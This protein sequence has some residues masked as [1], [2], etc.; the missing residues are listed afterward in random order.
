MCY[1]KGKWRVTHGNKR[2]NIRI[3][4]FSCVWKE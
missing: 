1:S 2:Q 3:I 4:E